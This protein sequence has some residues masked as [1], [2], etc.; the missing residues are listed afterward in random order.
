VEEGKETPQHKINEN[1]QEIVI[2]SY[3]SIRLRLK[4]QVQNITIRIRLTKK[5]Q[6]TLPTP[7]RAKYKKL[8]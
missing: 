5:P 2:T 3:L 4:I 1:P 8:T 7:P 6:R